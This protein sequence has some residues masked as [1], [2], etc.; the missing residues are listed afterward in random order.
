[1]ERANRRYWKPSRYGSA[2]TQRAAAGI[3]GSTRTTDSELHQFL[4]LERTPGRKATDGWFL[5]AESFYNVATE[6]EEAENRYG[7]GPPF[8]AYG[9]RSLHAQSH[10]ESFL[11]WLNNRLQGGGVYLFDE[12]ETALSPQRQL[13]VL[14]LFHRLV[15]HRSQLLVATHSPILLAYPHARILEFGP[16]GIRS[17]SYQ[18]TEQFRIT[19]D[20][21][22]R[23][24][25]LLKILLG[26]EEADLRS[27]E[28]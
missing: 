8:R 6:I 28:R 19:K 10:G 21:L 13:S 23:P 7:K 16:D 1:M 5:R 24:E 2:S 18:E 3:I 9:G 27:K 4:G 11:A 20:F 12:P 26:E 25:R 14:T 22:N 15:Y 17:V